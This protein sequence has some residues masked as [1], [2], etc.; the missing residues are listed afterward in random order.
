VVRAS[1]TANCVSSDAGPAAFGRGVNKSPLGLETTITVT[2]P[3]STA[4]KKSGYEV[5]VVCVQVQDSQH[6]E[7]NQRKQTM[8]TRA[9]ARAHTYLLPFFQKKKEE[10]RVHLKHTGKNTMKHTKK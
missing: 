10:W 1:A 3:A 4:P 5:C 9:H 7:Q 2:L 6:L 8:H